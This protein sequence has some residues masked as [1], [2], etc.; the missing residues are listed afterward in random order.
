MGCLDALGALASSAETR[1]S[2]GKFQSRCRSITAANKYAGGL[3]HDVISPAILWFFYIRF[4]ARVFFLLV[5]E[6]FRVAC[7]G[8]LGSAANRSAQPS[9]GHLWRGLGFVFELRSMVVFIADDAPRYAGELVCLPWLR[10]RVL[11]RSTSWEDGD[12]SYLFHFFWSQFRPLSL[13]ALSDSA[14]SFVYGSGR[15]RLARKSSS[16]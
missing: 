15:G 4:R 11:K 16:H 7:H 10:R 8:R 3:L 12:P 2:D 14:R 6:I 13:S 9:I 5:R 1:L